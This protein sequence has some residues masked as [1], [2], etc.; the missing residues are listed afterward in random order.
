MRF[1]SISGWHWLTTPKRPDSVAPMALLGKGLLCIWHDVDADDDV[2]LHHWY[3]KEHLLERIGI[4]GFIRA[5]RYS[6]AD[7]QSSPRFAAVYETET[8][9]TLQSAA[10]LGRLNDPTPL[11][12]DNLARFRNTNR[13]VFRVVAS[14]GHGIGGALRVMPLAPIG[15]AAPFCRWL[16]DGALPALDESHG[17]VGAHLLAGDTA[18]SRNDS[19]ETEIRET[20]DEISSLVLMVEGL[21]TATIASACEA[22][23]SARTMATYGGVSDKVLDFRLIHSVVSA[24][25]LQIRS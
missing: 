6:S 1:V 8:A 5:R 20:P 12:R 18:L 13:T 23:L 2:A 10:Y 24:D 17:I 3:I 22:Q 16:E 11:S 7:P 21:S 25:A 19:T 4:P 15:D 14:L 9:E